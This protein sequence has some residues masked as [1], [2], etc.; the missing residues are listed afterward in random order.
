MPHIPEMS[1][2]ILYEYLRNYVL[3]SSTHILEASKYLLIE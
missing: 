3:Y 2:V 1:K